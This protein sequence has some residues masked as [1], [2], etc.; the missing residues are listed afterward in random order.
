[1]CTLAL[2]CWWRVFTLQ[3]ARWV[4]TA[5]APARRRQGGRQAVTHG[6]SASGSCDLC[7]GASGVLGSQHRRAAMSCLKCM[8]CLCGA[9]CVWTA[10]LPGRPLGD[11]RRPCLP[12][13]ALH[14][15]GKPAL[16]LQYFMY[17]VL[18]MTS[19]TRDR[20]LSCM[21]QCSYYYCLGKGQRA[22]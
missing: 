16:C 2:R 22:N 4:R 6:Q 1:M 7:T 14:H 8:L 19:P 10:S 18:C 3:L 13:V 9:F 5:H 15:L 11:S 20:E 17:A 21:W 12:T